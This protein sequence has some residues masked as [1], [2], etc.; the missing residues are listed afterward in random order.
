[1]PIIIKCRECDKKLSLPPSRIKRTPKPFCSLKCKGLWQENNVEG[2]WKGKK[3]P[4]IKR[5]NRDVSGSKNPRW[6]GGKRIDKDGYIL[7][8]NKKHPH[9]DYHGYVREHR[10]VMEKAL[11]RYL[12]LTEVVHHK[13]GNKQQNVI[14]NLVLCQDSSQHMKGHYDKG[15]LKHLKNCKT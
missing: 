14:S 9:C 12:S 7:I 10:L 8:W 4:F 6:N 11:G 3:M 2:Y 13:N 15:D 1:M 5:P